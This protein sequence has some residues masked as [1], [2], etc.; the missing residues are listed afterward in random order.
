MTSSLVRGKYVIFN[1]TGRQEA[2][3]IENAAVFQRDGVIVEIGPYAR[4]AAK[5][6]ADETLG[7]P[8]HVVLPGFINS[9][10]HLGLTPLQTGSPD[11]PLELW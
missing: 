10:H 3:V 9:H 4:L 6:R 1:V 7:S 5:H 8:E 2:Q 11:F